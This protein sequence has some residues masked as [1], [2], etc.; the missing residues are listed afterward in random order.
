MRA[1]MRVGAI[2]PS[3]RHLGRALAAEVDL[4]VPGAVV[5]LGAGTGNVTEA[6]LEGGVPPD[7]LIAVELD[8]AL[9]R[10]L[11]RRF[12]QIR[13]VEGDAGEL[14]RILGAEGVA[15]VAAVV[16]CL[17]L[18]SLP[19]P[20][21]RRIV[22]EVFAVLAPAGRMVQFTY[23]TISPVPLRHFR[24]LALEGRRT[25]RIWRNVPPAAVW[26]YTRRAGG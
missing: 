5:E 22:A 19:G 12:P 20:L 9:A 11:R 26:R 7:R 10:I 21:V 17:P 13:V 18:V 8:P 23:G 3:G 6:L 16:S 14:A 25:R 1:P 2:W 15:Q 4:T 24:H